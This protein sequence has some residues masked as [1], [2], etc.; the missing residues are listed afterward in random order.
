MFFV[1]FY[2]AV[3]NMIDPPT[4]DSS[5]EKRITDIEPP[6]ITICPTNQTL[7]SRIKQLRYSQKGEMFKGHAI[8]KDGSCL[9]W[10]HHLNLTFD[11]LVEQIFD[12][13]LLEK[14]NFPSKGF[15]ENIV[16]LPRFG[17]CKEISSYNPTEEIRIVNRNP[18]TGMRIFLTDKKHRSYYSLDFASHQGSNI[19]DQHGKFLS[20]NVK[21]HIY[22]SCKIQEDS[23]DKGDFQTCVISKLEED[24]LPII[25]CVPPL[26]SP[27]N[28][29]NVTYPNNK[30]LS[31]QFLKTYTKINWLQH[32][33]YED[34]CKLC[35]H[36]YL[37]VSISDEII[38]EETWEF[39]TPLDSAVIIN[40]DKT[41]YITEKQFNYDSFQFIIDIGS[42]LGLWLGLSVLGLYDILVH[43]IEVTIQ[44]NTCSKCKSYTSSNGII[45]RL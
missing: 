29:C 41:V 25:G 27:F 24:L 21:V 9:S 36:M 8:C 3:L 39:T 17:F 32:S 20:L 15:K 35:Q 2:Q 5:F 42:S 26:M 18:F 31:D 11:Q 13:N 6:I 37:H 16:V 40:F 1:Q 7:F 44:V 23:L 28:Q 43:F 22:S 30:N 45:S 4:L 38:I 34:E 12:K 10:G 33:E 19:I 14:I